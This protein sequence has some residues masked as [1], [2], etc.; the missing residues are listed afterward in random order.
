MQP[1]N[2]KWNLKAYWK[3]N[4]TKWDFRYTNFTV[5][6]A[7]DQIIIAQEYKV[8]ENMTW[9]LME[10]YSKWGLEINKIENVIIE[11]NLQDLILED[12]KQLKY[13]YSNK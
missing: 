3:E 5:C 12:S 9:K 8:A 10:E 4:A 11:G 13:C 1:F 6:L 2:D 7:D